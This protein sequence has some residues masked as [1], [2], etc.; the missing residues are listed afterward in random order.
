MKEHDDILRAS[1]GKCRH[2]CGSST[3]NDFNHSFNKSLILFFLRRVIS[4]SVRPFYEKNVRFYWFCS[5][6]QL[7]ISCIEVAG[8]KDFFV[9]SLDMKH[10]SSGNMSC[11]VEFQFPIILMPGFIEAMCFPSR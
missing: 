7:R 8:K 2:K 10:R 5:Y 11:F 4:S 1:I 9:W 3:V 6:C